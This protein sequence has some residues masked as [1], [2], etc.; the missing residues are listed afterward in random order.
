MVP[1]IMEKPEMILAGIVASSAN[2]SELDIAG[3]WDRFILESAKLPYQVDEEK[4]YEVHV[5]EERKP[6]MH[7]CLIGVEVD[8]VN[9]LPLE[10]FHKVIPSGPYAVFTHH[11]KDGGYGEAFKAAYDWL[12]T[13]AY[14]SAYAFDIQCYDSRFKGTEDPDSVFEVWIPVRLKSDA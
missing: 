1:E 10:F 12:K 5:E 11:F 8:R 13:S 6:K 3:L 14:D 2:V 9:V 7:F 4:A